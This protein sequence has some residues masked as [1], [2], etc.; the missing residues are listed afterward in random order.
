MRSIVLALLLAV[1]VPVL[2]DI[3]PTAPG[4]YAVGTSMLTLSKP[5]ETTGEPRRLDVRLW[6]PAAE[7]GG[8]DA[9]VL[10][11]RWPLIVF[12]HGLCSFT[13]QSRYLMT[14]LASWG[15]V[16]A[17][18]PHPGGTADDF[19]L[20][21]S[22]A[23]IADSIANRRADV[24]FV[25]DRLIAAS[26][27]R[28]SPFFRRINR[29]RIGVTGHS[30][31]GH[32]ALRVAAADRRIRGAV[33]LSPALF[34]LTERIGRP[35]MVIGAELDTLTP[36]ETVSRAAYALLDGPRF[37]VEFLDAGHCAFTIVCVPAGCGAG[38]G[39]DAL[40]LGESQRL[41]R[42]YVVP[43]FLAYVAGKRRLV[44]QL[45][46]EVAPEHVLVIEARPTG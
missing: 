7:D 20:C 40:P 25:I 15:F 6:Y 44:R 2:A 35:L 36:F 21:S 17:A 11:R 23:G 16:V 18:P 22:A 38:C 33:A 31:G 19:P 28:D 8:G 29:K 12:S 5:S 32:T 37:L 4:P 41:T 39:L 45:R 43:F 13:L 10:R 30:F 42:R 3:D 14:S 24:M 34:G 26:A 9:P 27:A 1:P 46:P